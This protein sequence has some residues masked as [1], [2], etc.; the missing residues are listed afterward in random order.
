MLQAL[1]FCLP[2]RKQVLSCYTEEKIP[3]SILSAVADL[4]HQMKSSKRKFGSLQ[5][6]KFIGRLR[7]DN[8]EANLETFNASCTLLVA[9]FDNYQQQDA[10][11]FLNFLLNHIADQLTEKSLL[12]L[13]SI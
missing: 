13:F 5:P 9:L 4:Y 11:E 3:E 10:H 2:F 1:Y 8:G 12:Q 7:K 6:R